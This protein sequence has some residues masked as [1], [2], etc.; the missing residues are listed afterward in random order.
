MLLT[1]D[2]LTTNRADTSTA[3]FKSHGPRTSG[4]SI[5][6]HA[7]A[8]DENDDRMKASRML[9]R[10]LDFTDSENNER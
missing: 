7:D 6:G 1:N 10:N 4:C 3:R 9:R 5:L 2:P 8:Q